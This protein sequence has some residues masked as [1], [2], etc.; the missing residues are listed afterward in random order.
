MVFHEQFWLLLSQHSMKK[1]LE[2]ELLYS[3]LRILLDPIKLSPSATA[4]L[5]LQYLEKFSSGSE[6]TR[7]P[8]F[9]KE[10]ASNIWSVEDLVK[11][12]RK[13][14]LNNIAY[15]KIGYLKPKKFEELQAVLFFIKIFNFK[16]FNKKMNAFPFAP[17]INPTSQYLESQNTIKFLQKHPLEDPVEEEQ[18]DSKDKKRN[19]SLNQD[20]TN[21]LGLNK[22][23]EL[24]SE[25]LSPQ[26]RYRLLYKKQQLLDEELKEK[27]EMKEAEVLFPNYFGLIVLFFEYN[28]NFIRKFYFIKFI[29][30]FCLKKERKECTFAPNGKKAKVNEKE[31]VV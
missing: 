28:F 6:D 7:N 29:L 23:V 21:I 19:L 14:A 16:Y 9:S 13:L 5:I 3:V 2:I 1:F 30:I 25:F 11:N 10:K 12:F 24:R 17:K 22:S 27:R 15:M 20:S 18:N 4:S 8:I 26:D 31:L